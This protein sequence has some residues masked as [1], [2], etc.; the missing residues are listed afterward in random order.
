MPRVVVNF[1]MAS[2]STR[3][4]ASYTREDEAEMLNDSRRDDA[5]DTDSDVGGMSSS[6]EFDSNEELLGLQLLNE[7]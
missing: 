1:K 2:L 6:E 4:R 7:E 5:S 3:Q